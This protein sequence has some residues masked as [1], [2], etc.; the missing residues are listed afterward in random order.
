[1]QNYKR[2]GYQR[3]SA[4]ITVL[5]PCHD[6]HGF[7]CELKKPGNSQKRKEQKRMIEYLEGI[8]YYACMPK[9]YAGALHHWLTYLFTDRC[10]RHDTQNC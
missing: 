3:G 4:D 1:M 7:V 5:Y 9:G 6:Y 8:G 10:E 2:M